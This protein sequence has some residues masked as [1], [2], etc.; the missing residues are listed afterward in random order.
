MNGELRMVNSE[1]AT[2]WCAIMSHTRDLRATPDLVA[3]LPFCD[4]G[5]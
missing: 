5:G 3:A 4:I 1:K 2:L